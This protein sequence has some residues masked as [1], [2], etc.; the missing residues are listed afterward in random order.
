MDF[1]PIEIQNLI[2]SYIQSNT[3]QLMKNAIE[4]YY[5][6]NFNRNTDG[7]ILYKWKNHQRCGEKANSLTI[8]WKKRE[9]IQNEIKLYWLMKKMETRKC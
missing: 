5:K 3:N 9:M 1:L 6:R 7:K 4:K 8:F 2:F